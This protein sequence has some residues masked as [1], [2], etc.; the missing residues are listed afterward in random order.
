MTKESDDKRERTSKQ[1]QQTTAKKKAGGAVAS[2]MLMRLQKDAQ[3]GK[4]EERLI[5]KNDQKVL[6]ALIEKGKEQGIVDL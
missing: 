3:I 4:S 5:K 1:T 2:L 6:K